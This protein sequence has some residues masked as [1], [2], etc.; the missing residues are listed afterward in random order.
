MCAIALMISIA[1]NAQDSVRVAVNAQARDLEY[2]GSFVF[3]DNSVENLYD[4]LK[5][6]FRVANPPTGNTTVLVNGYTGDWVE[7]YKRLY[8]DAVAIN[9]GCAK[10]IG[11]LLKAA[12][13]S[14]LTTK[15][16]AIEQVDNQQ[17]Q[18][19]RQFGRSKLRRQ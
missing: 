12:G 17:H 2:V 19:K 14:Y 18:A 5:V 7:V 11:D 8:T 13:Q 10:R 4:S 16:D 9:N 3:N 6:K 15:I 1:C